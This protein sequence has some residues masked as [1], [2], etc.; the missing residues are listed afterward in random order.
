MLISLS[1]LQLV[2][3]T[4]TAATHVGTSTVELLWELLLY[5]ELIRFSSHCLSW[6]FTNW[7]W[8]NKQQVFLYNGWLGS[9]PI[10]SVHLDYSSIMLLVT[11]AIKYN[12]SC[13]ITIFVT[14]S[15]RI[16]ACWVSFNLACPSI[17]Y[18]YN[19]F[20]VFF[21]ILCIWKK[22]NQGEGEGEGE[23]FIWRDSG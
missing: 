3:Y 14:F 4:V 13:Q 23:S 22:G 16:V 1:T 20:I 8:W 17:I 10:F 18:I 19:E 5:V 6:S 21:G 7:L 2:E 9:M 11:M 12:R 15:Y